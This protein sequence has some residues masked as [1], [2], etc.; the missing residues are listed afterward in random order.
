[1]VGHALVHTYELAVPI[2]LPIWLAEFSV[3]DLGVAQVAVTT[4]TLGA[5]V[6]LGYG[7]FGVGALPAGVLVDRYGS[8]RLIAGCLAGMA[9]AFVLL[10][11]APN[12]VAIAVALVV[13]GVAASVYHPAGLAL[14]S[15]GVQERGTGFAYHGVAGN[16]GTGLGPL[17]AAV[18]LLV[19]EWRTVALLLAAPAL[20]GAAYAVRARFDE[21]AAVEPETVTDG[22]DDPEAGDA[23]DHGPGGEASDVSAS[24]SS[25]ERRSDGGVDSLTAF[26]GES[27]RLFAS[28]FALVF[29]VVACS[30]LYYRGILTF[31]P[32]LLGDLPGFEPVAVAAVL[33]DALSTAVGV[34]AGDGRTLEPGRY[35]YSALL[36]VGVVGQYAGGKLTDRVPVEYGVVGGFGVL[37][38]LALL[39]VPVANLGVGPLLAFG[40]VLGVALF[41]VQPV[42][43]ATVAEYTPADTR[44]LSYGFTYLGVFGVGALGATVAGTA[45]AVAG[46]PAL[47]GVLAVL[48]AAAATVG[49]VLLRR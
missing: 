29:V 37:A 7:L 42:E 2:F 25:S 4:A 31:L 8:R 19:L 28:A 34:E 24:R 39:F 1:M 23:G 45:L 5:V 38:V 10:G 20:V 17:A 43:Q 41:G 30:G 21:T 47:F 12:V 14:V 18:L 15:K 40:A 48:A 46:P 27:R 44:G 33:P 3:I 13:W 16:L 9:V 35:F 49:V 11:L 26:L 32:E 36:L 6:T 22:G